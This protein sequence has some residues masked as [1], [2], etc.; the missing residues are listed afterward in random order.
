MPVATVLRHPSNG[1]P[2]RPIED[3]SPATRRLGDAPTARTAVMAVEL[4]FAFKT[5]AGANIFL[6]V[7]S[8]FQ[9]AYI[10]HHFFSY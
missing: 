1:Y 8:V 6:N 3:F 5:I 9:W 2:Y 7:S 4:V 10:P